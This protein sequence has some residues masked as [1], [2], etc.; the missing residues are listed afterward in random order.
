MA[1]LAALGGAIGA[2]AVDALYVNLIGQQGAVMPGAREPLIVGWIT[3]AGLLGG[4]GAFLVSPL[5]RASVLGVSG[6]ALFALGV[7]AI[8]SIGIPLLLC[9]VPIS[10]AAL[11]AAEQLEAPR[12]LLVVVP[13]GLVG[14]AGGG[15]A[16]AFALTAP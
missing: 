11:K 6:A 9:A 8:S 5:S 16:L 13:I 1:S 14:L 15:I 12:W 4:V 2:L 7:P 3:S 10:L